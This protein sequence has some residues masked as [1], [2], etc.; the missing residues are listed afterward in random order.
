MFRLA[1]NGRLYHLVTTVL[2][3]AAVDSGLISDTVTEY[4]LIRIVYSVEI[5]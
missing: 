2:K 4:R 3:K 1:F 5:P